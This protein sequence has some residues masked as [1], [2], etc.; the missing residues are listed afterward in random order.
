MGGGR[1]GMR[2][3]EGRNEGEGEGGNEGRRE[4][5]CRSLI[6]RTVNTLLILT[7]NMLRYINSH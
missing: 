2:G 1:E 7:K 4:I 5:A 6:R 3:K